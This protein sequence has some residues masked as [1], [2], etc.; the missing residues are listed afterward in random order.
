[1]PSYMTR[2]VEPE[3]FAH[4]GARDSAV[5]LLEKATHFE[6]FL[7]EMRSVVE[8]SK[9][10]RKVRPRGVKGAE[11]AICTELHRLQW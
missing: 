1:M 2:T 4:K 9:S 3:V 8:K 7:D 10:S 6:R 5:H 11:K